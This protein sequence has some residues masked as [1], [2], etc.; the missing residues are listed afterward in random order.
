MLFDTQIY[1][2]YTIQQWARL[3]DPHLLRL[4]AG[5]GRG[6]HMGLIGWAAVE[7][8]AGERSGVSCGSWGRLPLWLLR[9]SC[10]THAYACVCLHPVISP[11]TVVRQWRHPPWAWL[12]VMII[13]TQSVHFNSSRHTSAP[14][15]LYKYNH[16]HRYLQYYFDPVRI[17]E[18]FSMLIL[19]LQWSKEIFLQCELNVIKKDFLQRNK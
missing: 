3:N 8:E 15:I 10:R 17:Y 19:N 7:V 14:F 1:I 11:G 18:V 2:V 12:S 5:G 6:E 16:C 4:C 13:D 9:A